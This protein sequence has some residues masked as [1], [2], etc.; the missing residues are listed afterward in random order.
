[1]LDDLPLH[2]D[3]AGAGQRDLVPGIGEH[4][5]G[6]GALAG[7]QTAQ[8]P[9]ERRYAGDVGDQQLPLHVV[10]GGIQA[11]GLEHADAVADGAGARPV[12]PDALLVQRDVDVDLHLAVDDPVV[13]DGVDPVR[14]LGR[15]LGISDRPGRLVDLGQHE[16]RVGPR[17]EQPD[18]L[19]RHTRRRKVAR[20]PSVTVTR[21]ADSWRRPITVAAYVC[22][23]HPSQKRK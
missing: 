11:A 6:L 14:Q 7:L 8:D 4:D 12:G 1:M 20:S 18:V 15:S 21:W 10:R 5:D 23:E 19:V 17:D 3:V 13:G 2:R 22:T 16:L 9:R